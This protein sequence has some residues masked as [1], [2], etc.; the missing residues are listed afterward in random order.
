MSEELHRGLV[1]LV[2]PKFRKR[3]KHKGETWKPGQRNEPNAELGLWCFQCRS[4]HPWRNTKTLGTRYERKSSGEGF[5]M[6]WICVRTGEVL[7]MED[8][9]RSNTQQ[10]EV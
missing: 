7:K 8:L 1:R 6:L 5:R 3:R 4:V 9:V 10:E 2:N